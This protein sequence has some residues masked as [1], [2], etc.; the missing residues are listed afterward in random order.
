[1]SEHKEEAYVLD[2]EAMAA[3]IAE[4]TG[5]DR[6]VV[7]QVLAAEMEYYAQEGLLVFEGEEQ[8]E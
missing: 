5:L 3:F 6:E 2:E 8:G 1:M 4:K 7:D